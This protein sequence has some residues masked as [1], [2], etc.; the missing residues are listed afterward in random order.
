MFKE[1]S[2]AYLFDVAGLLAGFLVAYQLGVFRL[3]PWALALYPTLI[4]TRVISG[5][6]SGRLST[7]LHLGTIYP[8][9]SGNTKSFY[10]LIDAIIVLTLVT[11]L[12]VSLISLFFGYLLWGI[13]LA[14]FSAIVSV[15]VAT[16][17]IGLLFSLV[18]IKVAF[19]SFKRGL[20]P[21][22]VVYPIISTAVSIFITLCYI[23]VLNL[24]FFLPY[25]GRLAILAIGF[26][27]VFL[28][29]YLISRDKQEPEFLKTISESLIMLL[30]VSIM[31]TL[32]G[33]IFKGISN[34]AEN[35][36]EIYT[37]YPALI[38]MVS[39]VGSVVG[40]TAN[41]KLALGLLT[42]S[43]SSIKNHT[44]NITSAWVASFLM[45]TVLALISLAVNRVFSLSSVLNFMVIIWLSN[46]IAVIGIALLSYWVSILT[47]K[48]G[49]D[50]DNFVIPVETS[51]ATIVTSTA[52]LLA[53]L[54]IR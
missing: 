24:F 36:K 12:T 34:F 38:N 11:S 31:V 19:V 4:S 51:F 53:L 8:R 14:D 10:K 5:L 22:I 37:I 2:L 45:F 44:K 49:L 20:D 29:L 25:L 33:T 18:T 32:T 1:T 26:T 40:S 54:L 13:T 52:L 21:D 35:R 27:H 9:F 3:S 39:N 43:F 41:T 50:P 6:L 15:M 42:P 7:A 48:R 17:A 30:F 47:F 28:V 23:G 46:V 16:L